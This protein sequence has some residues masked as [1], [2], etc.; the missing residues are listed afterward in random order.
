VIA[1][2]TVSN[3]V[4]AR[5][6]PRL[7]QAVESGGIAAHRAVL[8]AGLSWQVIDVGAG[9]GPSF[10]HCPAAVT[11]VVAVEP[12][13]RLR[14]IAAAAQTAPVPIKVTDGLAS[15]LP[16]EDASFDAAS[17]WPSWSSTGCSCR[18]PCSATGR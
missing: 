11:Q 3:P 2:E 4:F 5:I 13:P 15:Q 10:G 1:K 6:F 14:A 18:S 17:A 16:A 12:E 8:L 9:T 7:S